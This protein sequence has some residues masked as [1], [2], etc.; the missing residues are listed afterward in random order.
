M[1]VDRGRLC[2]CS[3]EWDVYLWEGQFCQCSQRPE[4]QNK[5]S[6]KEENHYIHK[7]SRRAYQL[8]WGMPASFTPHS[9]FPFHVA[10]PPAAAS[11]PIQTPH[12]YKYRY[13]MIQAPF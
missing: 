5:E 11:W 8:F 13:L 4:I 9:F 6:K 3:R 12:P 2:A 10:D 1:G 7:G